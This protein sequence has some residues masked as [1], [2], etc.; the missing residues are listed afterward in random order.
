[1]SAPPRGHL[2]GRSSP[3]SWNHR[4]GHGASSRGICPGHKEAWPFEQQHITRRRKQTEPIARFKFQTGPIQLPG[5][6]FLQPSQCLE[7]TATWHQ[8][9]RSSALQ[10]EDAEEPTCFHP[11]ASPSDS[12]DRLDTLGVYHW[13]CS[14]LLEAHMLT[15][16]SPP[17]LQ[18][19]GAQSWL[20][21]PP[22]LLQC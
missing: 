5:R 17:R 22:L 10:T 11:S 14:E 4:E 16:I 15:Q 2:L 20:L 6:T 3:Y 19:G 7:N 12:Q 8:E 1:M 18:Q 9:T 13:L 21:C